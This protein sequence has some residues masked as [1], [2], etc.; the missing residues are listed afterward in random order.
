MRMDTKSSCVAFLAI[1]FVL[2]LYSSLWG[3]KSAR[4][5]GIAVIPRPE[6][7]EVRPGY[8]RVGPETKVIVVSPHEEGLAVAEELAS[9]LR[10]ITGFPVRLEETAGQKAGNAILLR[11]KENLTRLG[12]E[13]YLLSVSKSL[14][15][16]DAM[17]P[18]GLFYGVQTFF[19]LLPAAWESGKPAPDILWQVP[20]VRIEDKPRFRWR[21][22]HLDVGRHFFPAESIKKTIDILARYKINTFHWH[23]TE[24]QGWRVEIKK[25][26]RL[27]E[28][29]AWRRETMD[30]CKPHGGFYTQEEI[31]EV[32]DYAR[33]RHITIV[34]EI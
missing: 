1:S 4:Q 3:Q 9:R 6:K 2:L 32:V 28:V 33:K 24:D 26:P 22:I 18:A 5:P 19:Q 31:R 16:I 8:F 15:V 23:L 20:C 29:G 21:G 34:P 7:L 30:D 25:Y 27:T 13:G 12:P 10:Q 17:T 11:T 14:A